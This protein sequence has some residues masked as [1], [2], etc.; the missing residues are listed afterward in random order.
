MSKCAELLQ[1]KTEIDF[2]D[3]NVGCP[4]EL[5]FNKV[6]QGL[7]YLCNSTTECAG[8]I[9]CGYDLELLMFVEYCINSFRS[10]LTVIRLRIYFLYVKDLIVG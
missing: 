3:V 4:I 7:F 9:M 6:N 2:I 10:N 8:G 1:S 5:V